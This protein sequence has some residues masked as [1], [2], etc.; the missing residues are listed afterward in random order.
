MISI[1]SFV[2]LVEDAINRGLPESAQ[3]LTLEELELDSLDL[4][5]VEMS[6]ESRFGK[7]NFEEVMESFS[8]EW[9]LQEFWHR[10]L[11]H[12]ERR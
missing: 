1:E 5:S 4:V 11:A 7:A 9:T 8:T 6:I 2:A 10:V 12:L 3:N